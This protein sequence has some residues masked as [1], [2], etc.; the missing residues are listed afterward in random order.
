MKSTGDNSPQSRPRVH[1]ADLFERKKKRQKGL[2]KVTEYYKWL[3]SKLR[4][5]LKSRRFSQEDIEHEVSKMATKEDD[6]HFT[7]QLERLQQLR[8]GQELN[9]KDCIQSGT[10]GGIV[11][12]GSLRLLDMYSANIPI[13]P[14]LGARNAGSLP[15]TIPFLQ[16]SQFSR[17]CFDMAQPNLPVQ[18]IRMTQAAENADLSKRLDNLRLESP[19]ATSQRARYSFDEAGDIGR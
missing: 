10:C 3:P 19:A 18:P 8:A 14:D 16:P 2:E 15:F 7:E 12:D 6:S 13:V 1:S 11:K 5:R 17:P 9:I 4:Q